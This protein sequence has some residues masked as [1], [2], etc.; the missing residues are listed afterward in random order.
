[1]IF[2]DKKNIFCIYLKLISI[3]DMLFITID[4]EEQRRTISTGCSTKSITSLISDDLSTF[5]FKLLWWTPITGRS[6]RARQSR[7]W[8]SSMSDNS[9]DML[10][11]QSPC[12]L[13]LQHAGS[14]RQSCVSSICRSWK[15]THGGPYEWATSCK[16][17]S[18]VSSP[19]AH[20]AASLNSDVNNCKPLIYSNPNYVRAFW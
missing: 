16:L 13:T 19:I 12:L 7:A 9:D 4:N 2:Y 6:S 15:P 8:V 18:M 14:G 17:D 1:M 3:W 20:W 11:A 5:C 10:L